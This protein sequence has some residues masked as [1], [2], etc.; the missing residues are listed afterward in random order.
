LEKSRIIPDERQSS[1]I[2]IDNWIYHLAIRQAGL[3]VGNEFE[4]SYY[5]KDISQNLPENTRYQILLA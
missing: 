1:I 4:L 5:G 2:Y 3:K